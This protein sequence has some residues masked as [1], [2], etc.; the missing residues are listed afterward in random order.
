M[1][2]QVGFLFTQLEGNVIVTALDRVG[3][4]FMFYM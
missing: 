2:H 1:W 4:G 3:L